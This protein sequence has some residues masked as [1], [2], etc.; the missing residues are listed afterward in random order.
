[1]F[2]TQTLTL[3]SYFKES[4]RG[5]IIASRSDLIIDSCLNWRIKKLKSVAIGSP[6]F[7]MQYRSANKAKSVKKLNS[8]LSV[9]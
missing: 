4:V 1:M 8:N 2:A 9:P 7:H 5:G 6:V 3:E